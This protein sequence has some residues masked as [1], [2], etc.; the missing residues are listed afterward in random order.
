MFPITF[1]DITTLKGWPLI[2]KDGVTVGNGRYRRQ[3]SRLEKEGD[4]TKNHRWSA[5]EIVAGYRWFQFVGFYVEDDTFGSQRQRLG[6]KETIR[7]KSTIET[8]T[9]ESLLT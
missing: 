5:T 7:N 9:S 2:A 1:Q 6:R 3:Y 4:H 8:T